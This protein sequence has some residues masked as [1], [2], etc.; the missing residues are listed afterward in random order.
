M[1]E[2]NLKFRTLDF[3]ASSFSNIPQYQNNINL[4]RN[5]KKWTKCQVLTSGEDLAFSSF[6]FSFLNGIKE[7]QKGEQIVQGHLASNKQSQLVFSLQLFDII[8]HRLNTS[9]L[10]DTL[11]LSCLSL[12]DLM[13]CGPAGH[14]ILQA[15]E[16]EWVAMP[17]SRGS[18]L[19]K[20]WTWVSHA[21]CI[22]R[23]VFLPLAPSEKQIE[24]ESH[25]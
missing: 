21:S 11:F 16:L 4:F 6:F 25:S 13:D 17:S 12:C 15:G 14:G 1:A 22:G 19:P 2:P 23:W 3:Q 7:T 10:H 18:S 24:S 8:P 5:E 20:D 9:Y